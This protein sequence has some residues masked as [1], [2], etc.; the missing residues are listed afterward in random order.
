MSWERRKKGTSEQISE[1]LG[2]G[3]VVV[4]RRGGGVKTL[5]ENKKKGSEIRLGVM[6]NLTKMFV[7]SN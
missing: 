1:P 4:G 2:G 5:A 6:N 3:V 7:F